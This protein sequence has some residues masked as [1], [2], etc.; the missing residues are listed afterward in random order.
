M[1]VFMLGLG[2]EISE[3]AF[4]KKLTPA[5]SLEGRAFQQV[6]GESV[7]HGCRTLCVNS[8]SLE[9]GGGE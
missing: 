6:E 4:M 2:V 5:R 1:I 3:E 8:K 7:G 9:I